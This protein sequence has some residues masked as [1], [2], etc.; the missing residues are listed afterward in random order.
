MI[1]VAPS[2]DAFAVLFCKGLSIENAKMLIEY[3]LVE[4]GLLHG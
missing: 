3:L 4:G 2:M 1:V